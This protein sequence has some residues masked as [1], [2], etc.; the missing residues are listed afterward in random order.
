[1]GR[2]CSLNKPTTWGKIQDHVIILESS[3][4]GVMNRCVGFVAGGIT[5]MA[6][7]CQK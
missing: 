3:Y 5:K 6:N 1:M 7:G 2:N 4:V